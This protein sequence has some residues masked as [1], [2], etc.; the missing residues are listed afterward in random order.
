[1]SEV[2][3]KDVAKLARVSKATV[4]RV[5][6]K[7]HLVSDETREKVERAI[8]ELNYIPNS[9]AQS[10]SKSSSRI[11]GI[12]LNSDDINPLL[13]NTFFGEVLNDISTYL[14]EN[15]Y[16]SLYIHC[17]NS[18]K[19]KEYIDFL[20]KSRRVDG[21]IFLRASENETIF[22]YL[23]SI[24][25]PFS[26]IGR[27]SD[28]KKYLWVDN[29]NVKSSYN[30]TKSLLDKGHRNICF[31]GGSKKLNVTKNRFNG[32]KDALLEYNIKVKNSLVI[33][34][35]FDETDTLNKLNKILEKNKIDAIVTTDDIFAIAATNLLYNLNMNNIEV[36][37]YNNSY[38]RKFA[39]QNFLTVDINV[40]KLGIAS[41]DLLIKKINKKII[42]KNYT[43]IDTKIIY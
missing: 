17:E 33:E 29:D 3:I 10:L 43:I 26:I 28:T 14:I 16:Y 11:L 22:K 21:L 13:N 2:T 32:Y 23:D 38:L 12:V 6:S 1:M 37:G 18:E 8:E 25:F 5:V 20:I 4:S 15:N 34:S 7:S 42:R 9:V 27:P 35:E 36:T 41:C 24:N 30:I 31:I 39:K 19:E 40:K